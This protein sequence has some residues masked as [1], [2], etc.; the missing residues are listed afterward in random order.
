VVTESGWRPD[1]EK[2]KDTVNL[3]FAQTEIYDNSGER[4]QPRVV[5]GKPIRLV[6]KAGNSLLQS[7]ADAHSSAE[8]AAFRKEQ[9]LGNIW[10]VRDHG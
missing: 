4:L 7:L 10:L 2:L 5:T 6:W 1:M 3:A 9:D 8:E